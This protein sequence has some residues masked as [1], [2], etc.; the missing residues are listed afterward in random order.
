MH[1]IYPTSHQV[2]LDMKSFYIRGI[3]TN[4]DSCVDIKK[5]L[6]LSAFPIYER[7]RRQALNLAQPNVYSLGGKAL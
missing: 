6:I 4:R 3:H 1:D 7:L 2:R 5:C